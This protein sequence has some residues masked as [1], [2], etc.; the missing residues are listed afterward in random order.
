[1]RKLLAAIESLAVGKL[2]PGD[3]LVCKVDSLLSA[4][5]R[6]SLEMCLAPLRTQ[7]GLGYRIVVLERGLRLEVFR[8]TKQAS[9]DCN[10]KA[11]PI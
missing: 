2:E 10:Q 1:M 7:L 6:Q 9:A 11:N 8:S 3:L 5:Q 4:A